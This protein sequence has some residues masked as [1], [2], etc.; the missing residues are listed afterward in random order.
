MRKADHAIVVGIETRVTGKRGGADI[1]FVHDVFLW[2]VRTAISL[3]A[4][5]RLTGMYA[6]VEERYSPSSDRPV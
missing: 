6:P 3:V 5:V 1:S 4:Y 2:R